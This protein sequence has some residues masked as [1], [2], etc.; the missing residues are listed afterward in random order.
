VGD[1]YWAA[2][3]YRLGR[4]VLPSSLGVFVCVNLRCVW[5]EEMKPVPSSHG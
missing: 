3:S 2:I 5:A 1:N 4:N